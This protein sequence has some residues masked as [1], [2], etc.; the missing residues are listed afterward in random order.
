MSILTYPLSI[1]HGVP[2]PLSISHGVPYPLSVSHGVPYPLS[3]SHGVPYPLSVSHGVPYPLSTSHISMRAIWL[4][5]HSWLQKKTLCENEVELVPHDLCW[6]SCSKGFTTRWADLSQ[7]ECNLRNLER[8]I[9]QHHQLCHLLLVMSHV[10]Q[11]C[12]I[13]MHPMWVSHVTYQ[14]I[15]MWVMWHTNALVCQSCHIPMHWYV[16]HVTYQCMLAL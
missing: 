3:M 11:S 5:W 12:H 8:S 9:E 16:S 15:G 6:L 2:Y 10:S 4:I 13:R 7:K 1:S 14:C